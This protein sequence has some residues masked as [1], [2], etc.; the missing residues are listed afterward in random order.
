LTVTRTELATHIGAAFL[1][2][3]VSRDSLLAYAVGSHA[4]PEVITMIKD[5]P[6]K[7]Y[8]SLRDIWYD[9]AE[10]PVGP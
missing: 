9:L 6:D 8:P 10:L 7:F 4:R 5:L 1:V 2:G 3:P